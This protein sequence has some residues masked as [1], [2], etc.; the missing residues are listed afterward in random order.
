MK[1][2]YFETYINNQYILHKNNIAQV[3]FILGMLAML[4][5]F[6]GLPKD[7]FDIHRLWVLTMY[8]VRNQ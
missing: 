6:S 4:E 7:G 8:P 1:K 3:Y 2:I 5:F